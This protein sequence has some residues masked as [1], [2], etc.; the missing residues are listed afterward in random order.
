MSGMRRAKK[1]IEVEGIAA[2]DVPKAVP[3]VI[4]DQVVPLPLFAEGDK[5]RYMS[6]Y[7]RSK[8][9]YQW[10]KEP[11]RIIGR[12]LQYDWLNEMNYA[13]SYRL[14]KWDV[15]VERQGWAAWDTITAW[16]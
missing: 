6:S 2:R 16:E 14:R 15:D 9:P 12:S 7:G 5:V 11:Y 8:T 10:E 4:R 1:V 3:L 13:Y